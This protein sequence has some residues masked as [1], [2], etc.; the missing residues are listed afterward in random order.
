ML[1]DDMFT[2][3]ELRR[4]ILLYADDAFIFAK[5]PRV[6][7]S[8]LHDL[9]TYCLRWCLKINA[10]K[11]KVMLFE[12]DEP[13]HYDLS[14]NNVK[15]ELVSS[16][17][18]LGIHFFTNWHRTQKRLAQHASIALH[19]LFSIV[20]EIKLPISEKCK[21]FDALVSPILNYGAEVWGMYE[22][23][24][25]EILHNKFCRWALNVRKSQN[26]VGLYGELGRSPLCISRKIIMIRYLI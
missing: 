13:T 26:L 4:F 25:V 18:Y 3:N 6:L 8:L 11:T 14:L 19:K 10:A 15:L 2:T 21:L 12:K 9:E 23:K 1:T 7:Q 20:R 22:A 16:F 5:S 17:K 24:D